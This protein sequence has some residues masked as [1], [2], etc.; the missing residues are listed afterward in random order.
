MSFDPAGFR[1]IKLKMCLVLLPAILIGLAIITAVAAFSSYNNISELATSGMQQTLKTNSAEIHEMLNQ[2]EIADKHMA[3]NAGADYV[4]ESEEDLASDIIDELDSQSLANGGGIWFEPFAYRAEKELVCPFTFRENGKLKADFNYVQESGSYLNEDWYTGGK[5][6]GKGKAYLTDPYFDSAAKVVMVTYAAPIYATTEAGGEKCIGVATVDISLKQIA[7]IVDNIK[8]GETGHAYLLTDKGAYLAGVPQEKLENT[9]YATEEQ[10]ASLAAAMKD[11]I[12]KDVGVTTYEEDGATQVMTYATMKDTGWSLVL[13]LPESELYA[14]ARTLV[15]KLVG[16]AVV[17]MLILMVIAYRT[18]D[19]YVRRIAVNQ[20]FA[21]DLAQGNYARETNVPKSN[22]EIGVLG[23]AMNE[24]FE[25]T[26]EVIQRISGQADNMTSSSQTLGTSADQLKQGFTSIEEKMQ[27]INEAMM[28]ASSATEEVNASV[29]DVSSAIRA[30]SD[31]A[32]QSLKQADDIRGRANTV[33]TESTEASRS[34]E[35][36]AH[37]FSSKL[38]TSI[39]Q[40]KT[41]EQIGAMATSISGIAE[42]INLLSLNASIEAARAGESGRGFAV[43]ATEIGKLAQE[44]ADTVEE[45]QKTIQAVQKAFANLS[46]DAQA[47]L[48]FLNDTVAPQYDAF[49]KVAEQYGGDA[50]TFRTVAE[51]I[52][53]T[54]Q[55]VNETMQQVSAAIEQIANSAQDTAELSSQVASDVDRVS[56]SVDEVN[57]MSQQ[58]SDAAKDLHEVVSHFRLKK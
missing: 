49:I 30:L 29:D 28:T 13:V 19:S 38:E 21:E 31:E 33:Q 25:K 51:H 11:A 10:N 14:S 3:Y 9:T 57:A 52:A 2:M 54:S 53:S 20:V 7:D 43:V 40:A 55:Q 15:W 4:T 56:G 23:T 34:A 46:G 42:Q 17:I 1:S 18:I 12:S 22:D 41:V 37:E 58:Q 48:G 35:K 5:N 45:I 6:A 32:K 47:I 26:K 44:T 24:M 39:E 50:E 16:I 8:V 36:L 27:S